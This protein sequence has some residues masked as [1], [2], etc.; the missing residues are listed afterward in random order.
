MKAFLFILPAMLFAPAMA[1]KAIT[2]DPHDFTRTPCEY[3]RAPCPGESPARPESTDN[4]IV[5]THQITVPLASGSSV[6]ATVSLVA[7]SPRGR[8]T[9]IEQRVIVTYE[10]LY[11]ELRSE[12]TRRAVHAR[13][14]SLARGYGVNRI[15]IAACRPRSTECEVSSFEIENALADD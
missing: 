5:E 12:A 9:V 13:L 2:V 10:T 15:D 6:D 11:R 8:D 1:Q 14:A 4:K 7:I 3:R